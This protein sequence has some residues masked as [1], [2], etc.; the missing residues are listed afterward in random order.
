MKY[1][2]AGLGNIGDEY[3]ETRH[4][5][6]FQVVDHLA[7]S[8]N[9]AWKSA[10]LGQIA[11]AKFKG[12][13]LVLLK[14]NTYMNLSGKSVAY[15]LQKEKIPIENLLV[16]V[17]EIQLDPGTIRLRGKGTDGG[18]NGLTDVAL[19]LNTI[20]YARLRV[21]IGKNFPVGG[22]I[23]YVLGKWSHEDLK[24]LPDILSAASDAVKAFASIGI[25]RAMEQVNTS[26]KPKTE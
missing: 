19:Q 14:P 5:I 3:A 16:I 6:G 24:I 9:A 8:L 1:L 26:Q 21:G 25:K 11:E 4:N 15:W 20:E 10:T 2:I 12:R 7:A 22:Q 23:K 13:I 17:D 18:H